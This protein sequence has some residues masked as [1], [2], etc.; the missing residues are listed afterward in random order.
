MARFKAHR[1]KMLASA[2]CLA[3][4][5][6]LIPTVA[7]AATIGDPA[8]GKEYASQNCAKCHAIAK[9][10]D[11]SPL[12]TAPPFQKIAD[13]PAMTPTALNVFFQS[14]HPSMP[15]FIIDEQSVDDLIAY[16]HS[17]RGPE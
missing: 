5:F 7:D 4:V 15:N 3:L 16:V 2:A 11:R 8:R 17:L 10:D 9:S 14:W 13:N 1:T 6:S 12:E